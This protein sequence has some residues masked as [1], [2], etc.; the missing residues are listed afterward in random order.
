MFHYPCLLA[1]SGRWRWSR[2]RN[3]P[4]FATKSLTGATC[5]RKCHIVPQSAAFCTFLRT[6]PLVLL[7]QHFQGRA[8]APILANK[9]A[10]RCLRHFLE[11]EHYSTLR[12]EIMVNLMTEQEVSKRLNVSV[13]SLRRWR[14]LNRGPQFLKV[15]SLVRYQPE[16][17]DAWLASLP[18]GG[19]AS[20][21][22]LS[23]GTSI[24][25]VDS[26]K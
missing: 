2:C 4:P 15:G 16:E 21:K 1:E 14:L 5:R 23:A 24:S 6:G 22:Q 17:L 26:S 11:V 10:P 13:A 18:T 7:S 12:G 25:H 20:H 19:T 8:V 3:S 9:S